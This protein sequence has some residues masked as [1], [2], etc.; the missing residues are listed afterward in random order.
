MTNQKLSF[1]NTDMS[2]VLQHRHGCNVDMG[3]HTCNYPNPR[4]ENTVVYAYL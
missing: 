2:V 3:Y 1:V 4:Y